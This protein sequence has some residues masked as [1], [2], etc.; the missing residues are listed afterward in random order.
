MKKILTIL[1][2]GLMALTATAQSDIEDSLSDFEARFTR[3]NRAYA[4]S[5]N[6]VDALFNMAQ[7]YFE[8]SNPMRNLPMAMKYIQ[9]AEV[10]HI[11]LLENEKLGELTRLARKNITLLTIRQTKQAITDAAYNTL[12]MRTDMTRVE[13]DTYLDAFGIDI[14]L[15]RLLRQ[16]RINQVYDE[17]LR[18]GT[19]Q[20]YYHFIDIYPGTN[21]AEQM[22]ERLSK[23][24]PSLFGIKPRL[25][26]DTFDGFGDIGFGNRYT[27]HRRCRSTR[28]GRRARTGR[29]AGCKNGCDANRNHGFQELRHFHGC[30]PTV[31]VE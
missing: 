9:R 30:S 14:E 27:V 23:L 19:A 28:I 21:E 25:S 26:T 5:P 29:Q 2:C 13:L 1:V 4:K 24:A 12:E 18:K 7:F 15:V 3:L 22:E 11:E 20:S 16:R 6:D 17:D 31:I 8:N 10:K